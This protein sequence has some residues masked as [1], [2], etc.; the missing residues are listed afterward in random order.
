MAPSYQILTGVTNSP[1]IQGLK[2]TLTVSWYRDYFKIT[3]CANNAGVGNKLV[4]IFYL[5]GLFYCKARFSLFCQY[6]HAGSGQI[7]QPKQ[8]ILRR[9]FE[10]IAP[11]PS[12]NWGK[13]PAKVPG[14]KRL[15]APGNAYYLHQRAV[16]V[17][18][19]NPPDPQIDTPKRTITPNPFLYLNLYTVTNPT[20]KTIPQDRQLGPLS[21]GFCITVV[22]ILSYRDHLVS[23]AGIGPSGEFYL[24]T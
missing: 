11:Y 15:A 21:N 3:T 2:T 22:T 4:A 9:D 7:L 13:F 19:R 5:P 10:K 8:I 12:C 16:I 24:D 1:L 18:L 23:F 6:L 20:S 14:C 17:H